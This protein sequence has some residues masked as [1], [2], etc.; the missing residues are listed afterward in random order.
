MEDKDYM[1]I[2]NKVSDK[3]YIQWVEEFVNQII[4]QSKLQCN[5]I[6]IEDIEYSKRIYL[7]IDGKEYDIRTWNF[8]SDE[9]DDKDHTCAEMVD[10]TLFRIVGDGSGHGEE[11]CKGSLRIEWKNKKNIAYKAVYFTI[12]H[13]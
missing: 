12:C 11:I 3:G 7:N 2:T 6:I 10:Y 8:Y 13:L 4:Q 1:K 9:K 5:E